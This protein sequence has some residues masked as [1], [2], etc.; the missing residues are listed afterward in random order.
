VASRLVTASSSRLKLERND[1]VQPG[2]T[3]TIKQR[4]F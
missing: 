1:K 4:L 2:D 3:L